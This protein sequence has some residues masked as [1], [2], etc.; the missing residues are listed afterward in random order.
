[1]DINHLLSAGNNQVAPSAAAAPAANL[2]G[3]SLT[4]DMQNA[5][6][7]VPT[8]TASIGGV[9]T[10]STGTNAQPINSDATKMF[11]N[12]DG[13]Q[14]QLSFNPVKQDKNNM[15]PDDTDWKGQVSAVLN[16]MPA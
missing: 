13:D 14:A 16:T 3:T 9:Q 10:Q 4:T 2:T 11:S 15:A 12:T 7:Q 6:A 8:D 1:M 5:A